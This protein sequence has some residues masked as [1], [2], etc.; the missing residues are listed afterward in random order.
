[1]LSRRAS[2]HA[3]MQQKG[4]FGNVLVVGDTVVFEDVTQGPKFLDDGVGGH[5]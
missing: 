1:M 3:E 4:E 2:C 5:L